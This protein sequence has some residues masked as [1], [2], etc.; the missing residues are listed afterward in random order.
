MVVP[1]CNPTSNR[2]V[3]L[4]L[5]ILATICYHLRFWSS[6]F[7]LVEGG[8]SGSVWF[9][10]S[11]WLNTLSIEV[12]LQHLN[13]LCC[14]FCLALHHIF[15]IRLLI[16]LE[17]HFLST[18]Y[19]LDISPL[20][21]VGLVKCFVLFCFVFPQSV[22]RWF[23]LLMVPFALQK[24]FSFMRSHLYIV[25]LRAWTISVLFRK[26]SPCQWEQG[27]FPFSLLLDSV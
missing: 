13:K 12:L 11:W 15:T 4:F 25:D 14:E 6:S 17:V 18:L 24:L 23:V 22:G 7:W 3:F 9:A 2:G 1:A 21:D 19:I 10:L 16:S 26:I 27:S 8:I 20:L 5:H